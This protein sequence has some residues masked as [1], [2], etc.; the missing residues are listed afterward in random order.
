MAAKKIVSFYRLVKHSKGA[1][2]G[3]SFELSDWQ[4]FWVSVMFGWKRQ[5]GLRRLQAGIS[6][7]TTFLP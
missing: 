5:N 2:A 7:E 6:P 3:Q 4:V 1:M